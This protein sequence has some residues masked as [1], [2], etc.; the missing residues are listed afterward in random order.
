M[1]KAKLLTPIKKMPGRT[2][3]Q[4]GFF[5]QDHQGE[6]KVSAIKDQGS[7]ILRSM[8]EANCFIVLPE[9]MGS[10]ENGHWVDIQLFD[11]LF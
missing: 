11:S 4:R 5:V 2:E 3:F 7:G 1:I 10:L 6:F 9:S 8:T